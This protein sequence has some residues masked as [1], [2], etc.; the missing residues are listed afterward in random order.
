MRWLR[1]ELH[2]TGS[3]VHALASKFILWATLTRGLRSIDF[4]LIF[5]LDQ[6]LDLQSLAFLSQLRLTI[7]HCVCLSNRLLQISV[8]AQPLD[9]LLLDSDLREELELGHRT[10]TLV[11]E[12]ADL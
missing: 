4:I 7:D 8:A 2:R 12:L 10:V 9:L 11:M 5:S 1:I 3:R 6:K